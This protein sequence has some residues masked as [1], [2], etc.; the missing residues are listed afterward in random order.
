MQYF[1]IEIGREKF[2]VHSAM[3]LLLLHV[4]HRKV[5]LQTTAEM[6]VNGIYLYRKDE[7]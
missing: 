7:R 5:N 1:L 3:T 2:V 4:T 6:T